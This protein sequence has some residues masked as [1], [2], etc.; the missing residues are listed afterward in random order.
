MWSDWLLRGGQPSIQFWCR[1]GE[2]TCCLSIGALSDTVKL[3]HGAG[4]SPQ[5][6]FEEALKNGKKALFE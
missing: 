1:N 2:Y 6:A 5:E 3:A 4:A